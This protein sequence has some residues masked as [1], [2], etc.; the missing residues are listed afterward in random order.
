MKAIDLIIKTE[1][2]KKQQNLLFELLGKYG[3]MLPKEIQEDMRKY[4]DDLHN[5][6]SVLMN[7]TVKQIK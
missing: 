6:V 3:D 7:R 4:A 5:E 2:V 1:V